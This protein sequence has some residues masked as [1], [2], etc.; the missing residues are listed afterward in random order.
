MCN[1][2]CFVIVVGLALICYAPNMVSGRD[3]THGNFS[4]KSPPVNKK[5]MQEFFRGKLIAGN[6]GDYYLNMDGGHSKIDIKRYPQLG[7]AQ[8]EN[9]IS[10]SDEFSRFAHVII[11][12]A[13]LGT[14]TDSRGKK[15]RGSMINTYYTSQD[16]SPNSADKLY[17]HYR[18]NI[19]FVFP[20]VACYEPGING[21]PGFGDYF[22]ANTAYTVGSVGASGTDKPF[23]EA[24]IY[25]S[26]SFNPLVKKTLKEEGLLMPTIQM[27]LRMNNSNISNPDE[28]LS[29]KAHPPA[30][31]G[32]QL[33]VLKMCKFATLMTVNTLPPM[34]QLN[35]LDE[36]NPLQGREFFDPRFKSDKIFDSPAAIARTFRGC[37][38]VKKLIVSADYSYDVGNRP[39]TYRW[40]ILR[41]EKDKIK[42]IPKNDKNSIVEIQVQYFEKYKDPDYSLYTNRIDIGAFVHNGTYF[43][44]PGFVTFYSLANE[45]R[46]YN[47]KGRILEI[48]Y[49]VGDTH[50]GYDIEVGGVG[51]NLFSRGYDIKDWKLLLEFL[52]EGNPDTLRSRLIWAWLDADHRPALAKCSKNLNACFERIDRAKEVEDPSKRREMMN[53]AKREAYT[54]LTN[55]T[56]K[57]AKSIK[58]LAEN[59]LNRTKSNVKL[60]VDN[61]AEIDLLVESAKDKKARSRFSKAKKRL[62]KMEI[63]KEH[64]KGSYAIQSIRGG[65]SPVE[66]RLTRY[67]RN[68]LE[69]FNITLMNNLLYPQFMDKKFKENSTD[70]RLSTPK[71]WSRDVYH[72]DT[73]GDL[74]GWSRYNGNI[75]TK[76][77]RNGKLVS[78]K[79]VIYKIERTVPFPKGNWYDIHV[80]SSIN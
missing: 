32:S 24:L 1:N 6:S 79:T 9:L 3:I 48:G 16:N 55:K 30:F 70:L 62:I 4:S 44:A 60:Y 64:G 26:A 75:I 71:S 76:Y 31:Y 20:A 73:N 19:M 78:G 72:Y 42:I 77:N 57:G 53:E 18:N 61:Q 15:V 59:A 69:W 34:I 41:G 43:S 58:E 47:D 10:S 5:S 11:G 27:I 40:V 67:E 38:K 13:S 56:F 37:K 23:L 66:E 17:Y 14:R 35:V 25:T 33:D 74:H 52:L 36:D 65:T 39:L 63:F 2:L 45:L 49:N 8:S 29:G 22:P 68:Q 28:Y 7:I 51:F 80:V 21:S 50:I 12:N 46:T 54:V